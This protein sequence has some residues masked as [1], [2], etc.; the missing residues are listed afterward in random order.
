MLGLEVD[1]PRQPSECQELPQPFPASVLGRFLPISL[2]PRPTLGGDAQVDWLADSILD[3]SGADL[4][5]L[6]PRPQESAPPVPRRADGYIDRADSRSS[7]YS[8]PLIPA[9]VQLPSTM[10]QSRPAAQAERRCSR[11]KSG[12]VLPCARWWLPETDRY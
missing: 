5:R 4:Q 6:Q 9:A 11:A 10:V 8:I 3:R 12:D 2:V 7:C 1:T